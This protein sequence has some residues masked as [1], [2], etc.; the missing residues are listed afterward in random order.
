MA[1]PCFIHGNVFEPSASTGLEAT[2]SAAPQADSS[3]TTARSTVTTPS[4]PKSDVTPQ[5]SLQ[6][7]QIILC[8]VIFVS[9]QAS[10]YSL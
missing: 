8:S 6:V 1:A 10:A 3:F 5:F 4:G 7:H 9:L 2:S